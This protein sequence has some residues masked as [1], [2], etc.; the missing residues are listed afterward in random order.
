MFDGFQSDVREIVGILIKFINIFFTEHDVVG[1]KNISCQEIQAI[2]ALTLL[3]TE[4]D[5][6][7]MSFSDDKNKLKPIP[8]TRETSYEK[9]ME[10]Y[11]KEIVS[12]LVY[13]GDL[14]IYLKFL[15]V[16]KTKNE[17]EY[18]VAVEE[19]CRRKETSRCL[20]NFCQLSW[21]IDG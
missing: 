1:M 5:V 9:A 15:T 19:S 14:K 20:H 10:I 7:V 17:G 4:K 11:E 13:F 12:F 16:G 3:K 18:K 21:S 8:W 6:T 2:V